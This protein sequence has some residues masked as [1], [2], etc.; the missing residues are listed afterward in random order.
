MTLMDPAGTVTAA[1][2]VSAATLLDTVTLAPP[3]GASWFRVTVHVLE[4]FCPRL[5]GLQLSDEIS[6]GATKLMLAV[7]A[8][9]LRLAVRV[10][11]WLV[12]IAPAVAVN[13]VEVDPAGTV[14]EAA[15][16][17]TVALLARSTAVPPLGAA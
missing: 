11:V 8:T 16:G 7:L 1:G 12:A 5:V 14:T 17:I 9:P 6:T 2:T 4:E 13:V 10:A 3:A 15:T